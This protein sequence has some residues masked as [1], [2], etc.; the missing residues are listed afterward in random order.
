MQAE[1]LLLVLGARLCYNEVLNAGSSASV[2]AVNVI[3]YF[4]QIQQKKIWKV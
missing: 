3:L 2:D 1:L 4:I